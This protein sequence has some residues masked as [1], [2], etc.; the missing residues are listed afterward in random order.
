MIVRRKKVNNLN[1]T[2]YVYS[3]KKQFLIFI[4]DNIFFKGNN[5]NVLIVLINTL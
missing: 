1:L 4:I 5:F 2:N 3:P